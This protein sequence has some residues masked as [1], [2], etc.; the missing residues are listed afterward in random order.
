MHKSPN[1]N[2]ESEADTFAAEFLMPARDVSPYL[3]DMSVEKAATLK[4]Y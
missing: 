1:Q 3:R 2:M 4:P